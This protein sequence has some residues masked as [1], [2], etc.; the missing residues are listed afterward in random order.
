[1]VN[2]VWKFRDETHGAAEP[3]EGGVG[4]EVLVQGDGV[5]PVH[6]DLGELG[7]GDAVPAGA[8]AVDLLVCAGGLLAELVAGEVQNLQAVLLVEVVEILKGIVLG[9]EATA[10]GGVDDE[11]HLALVRGQGHLFAVL[12]LDGAV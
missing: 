3:D 2:A 12:G 7:E 6:I 1:M 11:K 4:G 10:G 8:E 9:R 5:V